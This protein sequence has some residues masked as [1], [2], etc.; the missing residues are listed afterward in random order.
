MVQGDHK[1]VERWFQTAVDHSDER[2]AWYFWARYC[3]NRQ[4][5]EGC[6]FRAR[7]ALAVTTRRDGFTFDPAAWDY[8]LYDMAAQSAWR[9]G[10]TAQAFE[11]GQ[12]ALALA[13]ND[14]RLKYNQ[15][16]YDEAYPV[17]LPEVLSIETSSDCNR[18]CGTCIRNSDP[19]RAR[20]E[21]WFQHNLMS[22]DL[23]RKIFDDARSMGFRH[24]LCLSFF[25]EPTMDPRLPE[26]V[27]L[28]ITY[29]FRNIFMH[30]NG[31]FMTP[32]LA[33]QLDGKLTW[34]YFSLYCDDAAKTKRAAQ[35]REWFTKTD[36]RFSNGMHGV[37]H[38]SPGVDLGSVLSQVR[39]L[40]CTEPQDR[41][42]INHRGEM[43]MC[44]EDMGGNFELGNVR[45]QCLRDLWFNARHQ[46]LVRQLQRPGGRR[47]LAYCENC[48]RPCQQDITVK[49]ITL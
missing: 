21:P 22:W 19:D 10:I 20:V 47:G 31:D 23:I 43:T 41:F 16:F 9:I 35:L 24:D 4:D 49:N 40:N 37:T 13:P 28:A 45:D 18:T 1:Q 26:I 2:E 7:R 38:F 12:Q 15:A 34:I 5:W 17:P 6:Y 25:N 11:L 46:Q 42:I 29:P 36:V 33:A 27:D 3:F 14:E 30:S 48:P 44:C 8:S 32:E 39:D